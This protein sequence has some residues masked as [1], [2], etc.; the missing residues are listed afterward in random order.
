MRALQ[1]LENKKVLKIIS[2]EEQIVHLGDT[3]RRY[4]VT[5]MPERIVLEE[6]EDGSKEIAQL[7]SA[8]VQQ[9]EV[10]SLIGL[11]KQKNLVTI[12]R[13]DA[14]LVFTLT[15]AGRAALKAKLPEELF[16]RKTF[17]LPLTTLSKEGRDAFVKASQ[18]VY[19][20]YHKERSKESVA[21]LDSIQ[22]SIA[23]FRKAK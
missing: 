10:N 18:A 1:W 15:D 6:L 13:G 11:L 17:P 22:K 2:K 5:G 8:G 19:D 4:A 20:W 9:G 21:L 14:G 3:G 23:E 7:I 16:L 12:T